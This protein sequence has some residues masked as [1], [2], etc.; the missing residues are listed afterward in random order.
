VYPLETLSALS[1]IDT[2][3]DEDDDTEGDKLE[4]AAAP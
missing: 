4:A 1:S 3:E 2:S